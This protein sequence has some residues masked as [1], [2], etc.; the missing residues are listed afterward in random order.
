MQFRPKVRRARRV[1][2]YGCWGWGRTDVGAAI[3]HPLLD[4]ED[5]ARAVATRSVADG[6]LLVQR[7]RHE[8]RLNTA[9]DAKLVAL[10][11]LLGK[12]AA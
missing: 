6:H 4:L 2:A 9:L 1:S 12:H 10:P 7:G 11:E 5:E 8:G 3:D